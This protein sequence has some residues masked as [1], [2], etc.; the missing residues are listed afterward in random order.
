MLEQC[1]SN[2]TV[3]GK[4]VLTKKQRQ[5]TCVCSR[6]SFHAHTRI[7]LGLSF[8]PLSPKKAREYN[9]IKIYEI[10]R[11]RCTTADKNY[12][13]VYVFCRNNS[14]PLENMYTNK[15]HL[16]YTDMD[17]ENEIFSCFWGPSARF[18]NR[19]RRIH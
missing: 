14:S 16:Y 3:A 19:A 11:K 15:K 1:I 8:V 13:T 17:M 7:E 5:I 10:T 6:S 9:Y 4:F 12:Y 2:C 18:T